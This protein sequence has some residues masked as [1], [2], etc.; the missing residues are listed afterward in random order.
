M[1]PNCRLNMLWLFLTLVLAQATVHIQA[2]EIVVAQV[3]PFSGPMSQYAEQTHLGASVFFQALNA[4]GGI[5]GAKIR[6]VSRDDK[7]DPKATVALFEEVAKLEQPVAFL[8]PCGPI[9]VSALL[10]QAVP[11]KLGIPIIGTSPALYKLRM[12]VN[13]FTFHVGVGEDAELAKIVEHI[14]T[15]GIRRIGVAYWDD[16]A[17]RES[18]VLI[19]R[20]AAERKVEVVIK[21]PVEVGTAKVD[22]AVAAVI[23]AKPSAVIVILPVTVTGAFVK[24]LRLAKNGTLVYGPSFTDS[25]LLAKTAGLEYAR[26][27]GISQVVPNP[28]FGVVPLMKEY[29]ESMKRYAP[30]DARIG[31]LSFESYIAAKILVEGMRRAGTTLSGVTVKEGLEKL[32]NVDLGG[33]VMN[34]DAQN[35]VALTFQDI[36]VVGRDGRLLY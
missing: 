12:P 16:P 33:V 11:Q 9:G 13:P 31:S 35:H 1:K 4:A 22:P 7:M 17:A 6:F 36:S 23:N 29:Q 10:Q 19:E 20:R 26:G 32:R 5:N 15:L 24:G 3:A 27:V 34:Y 2:A 28:F 18:V 8:Y 14:A 25:T 21:A 30:K